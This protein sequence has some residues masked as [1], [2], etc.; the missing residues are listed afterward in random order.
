MLKIALIVNIIEHVHPMSR[1]K[2]VNV[3]WGD[4]HFQ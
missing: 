1:E 2:K 3:L 4:D